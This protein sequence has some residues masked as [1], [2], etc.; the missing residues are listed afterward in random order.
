[1]EALNVSLSSIPYIDK[2]SKHKMIAI[3]TI[4]TL[5]SIGI[6]IQL[7]RQLSEKHKNRQAMY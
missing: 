7:I 6:S 2:S 5:L 3:I 1:M 4:S